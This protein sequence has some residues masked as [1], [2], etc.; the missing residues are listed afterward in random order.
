[1]PVKKKNIESKTPPYLNPA[2]SF[3]ERV[4]DLLSR[5]TLKEKMSQM[6]YDAPAIPRLHIPE[7]NWWNECL[8]GVADAGIATVFPQ[9]IGLGAT[10]NTELHYQIAQTIGKEARAKHHHEHIPKGERGKGQGLTF[11]SPNINLF[12]DPRWGR[13]QETYGECPYLTGEMGVAFIKGLQGDH[14]KYFRVIATPK[15][16]AVHSGP[17]QYRHRMNILINEKDLYE[18]YLPHFKKCITEGGAYSMMCAYNRV[19]EY[20]ACAHSELLQHIL[21]EEWGFKGFVVS[22]C[23]AIA[24]F[25]RPLG[26]KYTNRFYKSAAEAVKNGCDLNCG[27]TYRWLPI[28]YKKGAITGDDIDKAIRRLFLARFRLGMFDPPERC[29]YQQTPLEVNDCKEHRRLALRAAQES[30]V[31]LKNEHNFLPYSREVNS[32]AVIGPNANDYKVLLANYHG[33]FSKYVTP[34]RGIKN[35]LGDTSEIRYAQGCKM[36]SRSTRGFDEAMEI[37][38]NSELVLMVLGISQEYEGEDATMPWNKDDRKFL[39]LPTA[40]QNLL[41]KIY[42]I[43]S[44][45]ILILLNGS[46]I[47]VN[48][49]QEH[50]PAIIEAWYPGEIGGQAIADVIFGDYCPAGRLPVTFPRSEDD[51]PPFLD[52][53]MKYRTYRYAQAEPLYPFGFGLS[54]TDFLYSNLMLSQRELRVGDSLEVSVDVTNIGER[55]GEEVVQLYLKDVEAS[56]RIPK[57][58]LRGFKRVTLSQREKKNITFNINPRDMALIDGNGKCILEPG[59][60]IVYI[61]GRQPD[62]RSANLSDSYILEENFSVHGKST[63]IEY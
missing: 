2:L 61:G 51:L 49:A 17:E 55:K 4:D 50:I 21:R 54:Y 40:Q 25:N 36:G 26:H 31:L 15:H 59:R 52:Y 5:M 39:G 42:G 60:F 16:Y 14:P 12:R 32:I 29:Q 35:K 3:E 9:A 11:W 44:N 46:P 27:R 63:E 22:D 62:D 37:A 58:G 24:D 57:Y 8:H 38:A 20:P 45:I 33:M 7:Y 34:L 10:F 47:I 13:G 1:M 30:I 53:S 56:V 18:S 48:W 43:N 19:N 23:G 6:R 28:A 41:E